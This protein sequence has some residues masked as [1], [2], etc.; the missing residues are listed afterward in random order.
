[1][2]G[3]MPRMVS[4]TERYGVMGQILEKFFGS[5]KNKTKQY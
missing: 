5:K 4:S 3:F 1:M 2:S